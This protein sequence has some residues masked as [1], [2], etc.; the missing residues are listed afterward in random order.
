MVLDP[1]HGLTHASFGIAKTIEP[2]TEVDAFLNFFYLVF[3]N[4]LSDELFH[5]VTVHLTRTAVGMMDEHDFLNAEFV[6]AYD[7]GAHH[8]IIVIKNDAASHLHHFH[9]TIPDA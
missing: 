6:D 1:I 8:G 3:R 5:V 2:L 4:A 7:D 9:L